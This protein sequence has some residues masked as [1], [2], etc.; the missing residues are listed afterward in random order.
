M[1]HFDFLSDAERER[2][3]HRPPEHLRADSTAELRA[4]ALGATLYCPATRPNLA[5]DIVRR[6]AQGVTSIVVCLEDSVADGE[7]PAAERNALS[8]LNALARCAAELP[9]LFARVRTAEQIPMLVRGLGQN[10]SLLSGFVLPKFNDENGPAFLDALVSASADAGHRLLAMPVLESRE[11][12]YKETRL[13]A[14]RD[15]RRLLDKYRDHVLA[16]RVGA[17]DLSSAYALR[18]GRDLTV[19]D[20]RV[21]ADVIADM[22]N[23]LGRAPACG[24][25]VTPPET[26][27]VITGPVWEY[28]SAGER[29]FK[30]MLRESPFAEHDERRLRAQLI[31][32]DLD[33]LIREV[34]LDRANG[35]VGK[36]VIHPSH[37]AAVHAL[38]VVSHEEYLDARDVLNTGGAGGVSA[39][40]YR[41][42]M[43]ESKPHTAWARRTMLRAQAFGVAREG[44]SFVDLLGASPVTAG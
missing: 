38:S 11:V 1:R 23:V 30:P 21:V 28:F 5:E 40:A 41:N 44:I 19:Y 26:G 22:V 33:G 17:T 24:D 43:N 9:M 16:V 37:V 12:I 34:V 25:G 32:A 35:L 6:A 39:S 18:R 20:V 15:A 27:Y 10:A 31:A 2:L 29:L 4:V 7:L 42:K 3:F 36:T 8:Q 14:L 13:H